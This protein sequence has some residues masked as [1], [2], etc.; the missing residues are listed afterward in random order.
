MSSVEV[1][2]VTPE[3]EDEWVAFESLR[4]ASFS[5]TPPPSGAT[6]LLALR[7]GEPV[8][9]VSLRT[10]RD[11]V[12]APG[13][14]GAVGHFEARDA[15]V[16]VSLLRE[17]RERLRPKG[18]KRILGP[19]D[20]TTWDRYRLALPA[21]DGP[22]PPPFFSEPTNPWEYPD[23]FRKAAFRPVA[24][25]YSQLLP[26]LSAL[27][28]RVAAPEAE[29]LH[30]G[31]RFESLDRSRFSETLDEI[32]RVSLE[33]FSKNPFY[34]PVSREYFRTMYLPL[35]QILDPRLVVLI[36][37]PDREL[38]GFSL[39]LPDLLDPAGS[40]TRIIVKTIALAESARGKG[41]GSLLVHDTHRR[42]A[43][44][45]YTAAI[46]ALMHTDNPSRSISRHGGTPFRRYA[47]FGTT[48]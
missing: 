23:F 9:R 34:T 16:G 38:V 31:Y 46:H 17:A 48:P 43:S 14:S 28:N 24:H 1:R 11:L 13:L 29:A 15:E 30:G 20:G 35:E 18:V 22:S 10:V 12:G 19:M 3:R 7:R 47:L 36:R 39:G 40:P 44:L 37:E 27:A 42:A 41:L 2:E 32:Y 33:A 45:G 4:P 5:A 21:Q 26:D 8:G 25:Y 6:L